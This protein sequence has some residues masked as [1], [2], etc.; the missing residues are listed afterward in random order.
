MAFSEMIANNSPITNLV[1][2]M[3]LQHGNPLGIAP[4]W[5]LVGIGVVALVMEYFLH[6]IRWRQKPQYYPVMFTLL[7]VVTLGLYYYCFQSGLPEY[8]DA[9]HGGKYTAIAWFC[10]HNIVGWG[11]AIVGIVSLIVGLYIVLCAV[12]QTCAQLTMYA[13]PKL[14]KTK[15]WKELKLG[16]Y[17]AMLPVVMVLIGLL[18]SVTATSWLFLVGS[19]LL[20]AFVVVK[21]VLDCR[22]THSVLWGVGINL[23]FLVGMIPICILSTGMIENAFAYIIAILALFTGAKARKKEA[24]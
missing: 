15:P 21:S 1:D 8:F 14:V 9:A 13:D 12:Q 18:I 17:V 4:V 3:G 6:Q 23:T 5:Q 20:L 19:L 16:V 10:D 11:W 24:K 22:R 7:G 2:L